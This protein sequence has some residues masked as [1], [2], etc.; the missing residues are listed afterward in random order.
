MDERDLGL[1][2]WM[3]DCCFAVFGKSSPLRPWPSEPTVHL[4]GHHT[5][6]IMQY[7]HTCHIHYLVRYSTL[8]RT[9]VHD[10][11][12]PRY[13]HHASP[14]W[15]HHRT[16][17][18][19]GREGP[20]E[21]DQSIAAFHLDSPLPLS[22]FQSIEAKALFPYISSKYWL[23][24]CLAYLGLRSSILRH[25]GTID[26]SLTAYLGIRYLSRP[27]TSSP[28]LALYCAISATFDLINNPFNR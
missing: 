10:H 13:I 26:T 2:K 6:H 18:T 28:R 8:Q 11:A 25:Y 24:T 17:G 16:H 23:L 12:M 4:R 22:Y 21:T 7:L 19:C 1:G 5:D 27:S 15:P 20:T 3:A 14:G 9:T